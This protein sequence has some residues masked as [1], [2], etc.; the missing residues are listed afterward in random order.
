VKKAARSPAAIHRYAS[1]HHGSVIYTAELASG[2]QPSPVSRQELQRGVVVPT[3]D[4]FAALER[5]FESASPEMHLQAWIEAAGEPEP[6]RVTGAHD[7]DLTAFSQIVVSPD[8]RHAI[9]TQVHPMAYA[10]SH[11]HEDGLQAWSTFPKLY[12]DTLRADA[13]SNAEPSSSPFY[14]AV[15]IDIA[16]GH[17][18]PLP[19]WES[20][21]LRRA[22]DHWVWNPNSKSVLVGLTL[23]PGARA[24]DPGKQ[25]Y[26]TAEVDIETGRYSELPVPVL[27]D[28]QN[29]R[30]SERYRPSRWSRAGT[31]K[32][33]FRKSPRGWQSVPESIGRK[34]FESRLGVE[35]RQALNVPP[36]LYAFDRKTGKSHLAFDLNEGL[37]ESF[38][39]AR[40]ERLQWNDRTGASFH[41]LVYFPVDYVAGQRY[42]LVIQ[43]YNH[44]PTTFSLVGHE[45]FTTS[46]SAQALANRNILVLQMEGPD[47]IPDGVMA[48]PREGELFMHGYEDAIRHLSELGLANADRVG[49][50]GFSRQ[51]M[52]VQYALTHSDFPYKAA[53][54]S[55]GLD[56]S[57]VQTVIGNAYGSE[58]S[59][60][61]GATPF[62]EGLKAWLEHAPGFN[63][64]KIHTPLRIESTG[65]GGRYDLINF[66]EMY[67]RLKYL[68]KP[69][70]LFMFEDGEHNLENPVQQLTSQQAAV[71]WYV[72][73][74][75]DQEDTDPQKADQYRR[76][77]ELRKLQEADQQPSNRRKPTPSV[78]DANPS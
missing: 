44:S 15:V 62:G 53:I 24:S 22:R 16:S 33:Y 76:W 47:A 20:V 1:D 63:V 36:A 10:L 21:P 42:P 5:R 64:E 39:L 78:P 38:T 23:V 29:S 74:L 11:A 41:G 4:L 68:K 17:A 34:A 70:E 8:G 45:G 67:G 66:W 6:R 25:G 61:N 46:Y 26:A 59:Q 49:I 35:V 73:W 48:S 9:G 18:T 14:Q 31:H 32:L 72:F 55:D 30:Y 7:T 12:L 19:G 77:R 58:P 2:E 40:V 13:Q 3:S 56:N 52:R 37:R 75:Q 50:T 51:S 43:T 60:S 54:A 69:V 71:D 28:V 65:I 27:K 57:Y